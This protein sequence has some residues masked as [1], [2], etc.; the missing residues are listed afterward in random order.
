MSES[1][2]REREIG[3]LVEAARGGDEDAF[4]RLV[5]AC[6]DR[7]HRWAWVRTGDPDDADEVAQET[8]VRLHRSLG[9]YEGRS[10]F[11]TWL[12][13]IVWS[14]AAELRRERARR[15][16]KARRFWRHR[17]TVGPDE[18]ASRLAGRLDD[19]QAA[20]LVRAFF[21][22]LPD[23]Q[24]EAFDLVDLQ[25]FDTV[26]AAEMMDL[27]PVTV[28]THLLRA[29]RSIRKKMLENHPEL[30]EGYGP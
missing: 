19:A 14:V 29:R 17:R 23:R 11:T 28:R 30:S 25:G 9:G 24:R 10:R 15:D 22:D 1:S 7:I 27:Q 26:E 4:A 20:E 21:R 18:R 3:E 8:L 16:I 6:Y 13:R 2:R 12:Y 5:R